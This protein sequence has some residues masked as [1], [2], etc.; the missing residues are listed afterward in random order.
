MKIP[1]IALLLIIPFIF[2]SCR[3]N[4]FHLHDRH[5][6]SYQVIKNYCTRKKGITLILFD[7]HHDIAADTRG[8]VNRHNY[9]EWPPSNPG[10]TEWAGALISEGFIKEIYWVSDR[11]MLLPNKNARKAWLERSISKLPYSSAVDIEGKVH[12]IDF[13]ELMDIDFK[14]NT[15]VSI[16]MDIFANH[17][18]GDPVKFLD[19][20]ISW[21]KQNQP[22]IITVAFSSVYQKNSSDS[23]Q[24]LEYLLRNGIQRKYQLYLESDPSRYPENHDDSKAWQLWDIDYKSFRQFPYVFWHDPGLWLNL[25]GKIKNILINLDIKPGNESARD[26]ITAWYDSELSRLEEKFTAAARKELLSAA[27]NHVSDYLNSREEEFF[28]R[29]QEPKYTD[30]GN[31]IAV[32]IMKKHA[33]RGCMA[34]YQGVSGLPDAVRYCSLMACRD[35]R[36]APLSNEEKN[37]LLIELSIFGKWEKM[38]N[39]DD[40]I[41][42][43]HSLKVTNRSDITILQAS[44]AIQRKLT[45]EEFTN[46]ILKKGG[47]DIGNKEMLNLKWEKAVTL[48]HL[49][50]YIS[51]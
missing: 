2:I 25:P 40:Y 37:Q 16:D 45:K 44:L 15:A 5:S 26:I 8:T 1:R 10:S 17:K 19:N 4:Q 28:L 27:R 14:K 38:D 48:W 21:L 32:R 35:P 51:Y 13:I 46:T 49:E 29:S 11:K 3:N 23:L 22:E 24:L 6:L 18:G 39:A 36:Y 50:P 30:G 41:P 12:V 47:I 31:G 20:I 7:Y 33:D 9:H 43:F 34:L 42:G